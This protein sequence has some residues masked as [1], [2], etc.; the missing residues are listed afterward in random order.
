[1]RR[2]VLLLA[3]V[4]S[5]VVASV[6]LAGKPAVP[7]SPSSLRFGKVPVTTS[8]TLELQ[9]TNKTVWN[10]RMSNAVIS[11]EDAADFA[12]PNLGT[13]YDPTDAGGGLC[14][15]YVVFTP[16]HTGRE[17]ATITFN[18]DTLDTTTVRVSGTGV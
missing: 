5:L 11:G 9:F 2:I 4:G 18:W 14:S 12:V 3:L 10:L 1:M 13:C 6:S 16:S 7:A 15:L 17:S 8:S